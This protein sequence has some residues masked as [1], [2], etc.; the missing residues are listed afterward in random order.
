M[1]AA[2]PGFMSRGAVNV[3]SLD[4]LRT[5]SGDGWPRIRDGVHARLETLLRGMLG[6]ADFFAQINE[7]AYLVCMPASA[8][9]EVNLICLRC[10][11]ELHTSMLGEC[12]IDQ[13]VV[14][15][16]V[17]GARNGELT[18]VPIPTERLAT[19][20]VKAGIHPLPPAGATITRTPA[21]TQPHFQPPPQGGRFTVKHQFL[22]IWSVPNTAVTSYLCEPQS[23]TEPNRRD[24]IPI[25][26][27][28]PA[29]RLEI[30]MSCIHHG[31]TQLQK[32]MVAGKQFILAIGLPYAMVGSPAGRQAV[33]TTLRNLPSEMRNYLAFV[34]REVPH[35]VAQSLLASLVVRLQPYGRS[36][37]ATVAPHSN[38]YRAY[39]D[40]GLYTIGFALCEFGA[41][42]PTQYEIEELAL[43]GRRN[44]L[45]TFVSHVNNINTL[46][47][48]QDAGIQQLSGSAIAPACEVPHGV[49]RLT[50]QKLTAEQVVEIWG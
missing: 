17:A 42:L 10:A 3:I 9:E 15:T 49:W 36:V 26:A 23:I 7:A 25:S 32:A 4:E 43:F 16:A 39:Q 38:L 47:F 1:I 29:P 50:W 37:S 11:F 12:R 30:E 13:L 6:P 8:P 19:L 24:S 46:K 31:I 18:V 48:V 28:D 44:H 45:G 27:F 5:A 34:I 41:V 22:P 2:S 14:G 33:I 21:N 40:I 35:G 20:A